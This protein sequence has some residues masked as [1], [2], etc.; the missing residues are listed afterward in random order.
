MSRRDS[1]DPL[2]SHGS[3]MPVFGPFFESGEE[4]LMLLGTDEVFMTTRPF[5]DLLAY[6]ETLQQ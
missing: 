1:R 3:D 2:V 4:M 5:V 6:S